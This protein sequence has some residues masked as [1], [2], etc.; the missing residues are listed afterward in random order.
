MLFMV[1]ARLRDNDMI[2]I[3]QRL[4]DRGRSVLVSNTLIA[5]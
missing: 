2:P 5:G 1:V 4:Q 3:Y